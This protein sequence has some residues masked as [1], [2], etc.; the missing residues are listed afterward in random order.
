[1]LNRGWAPLS[2]V[3]AD[4]DKY[5]DVPIPERYDLSADPAET[6]NL[7]DRSPERDRTLSA[8]LRAFNA[9]LPGRRQSEDPE[10][11]AR[12][13]SLGYVTGDAP[14]KARYTEA[15]D[16]KALVDVDQ[17]VH[18]GVDL[19]TARRYD[20]A[21][22]TYREIIARR[23]DMAVAYRHLAFVAWEAGRTAMAIDTLHRAVAA[24]VT[25]T[26]L[27]AQLGNYLAESGNARAAIPL[28]EPIASGES[29]DPD[30]LNAMGIAYARAG[31]SGDARRVFE[32]M[33]E[34]DPSSGIAQVNLGAL[35]L[36]RGDLPSARTHFERAVAA[37]PTSSQAHAGLGVVAIKTGDRIKAIDAWRRA[38]ALDS[39]NFDALFNL[40]TTLAETGDRPAARPYLEQFAQTA[41]PALYA[42][43]IRA[44]NAILQR[45]SRPGG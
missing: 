9:P 45:W 3:I 35:D 36:E 29:A 2:G 12:L 6:T 8:A 14:I 11:A 23:P 33:L 24:G 19:Y 16:P 44:V 1:M 27:V 42:S 41:P 31:R 26:E 17:A 38:V 20:E 39:T 10:A 13:R 34:A 15:D 5:I 28:L 4:R 32:R 25:S 30:A 7:I 37:D 21:I 22:Q 18:R 43:D 40:G